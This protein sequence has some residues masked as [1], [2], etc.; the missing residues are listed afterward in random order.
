MYLHVFVQSRSIVQQ[1]V[2]RSLWLRASFPPTTVDVVLPM[3][4]LVRLQLVGTKI[5]GQLGSPVER[6][7]TCGPTSSLG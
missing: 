1:I 4:R 5:L 6:N 2:L 7:Y 3:Q